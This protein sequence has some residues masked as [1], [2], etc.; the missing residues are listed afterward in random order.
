MAFQGILRT[1][2]SRG[3]LA[4]MG[5]W[6]SRQQQHNNMAALVATRAHGMMMVIW[7]DKD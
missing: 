2:P 7:V 3:T 6:K 4:S 5:C 1:L